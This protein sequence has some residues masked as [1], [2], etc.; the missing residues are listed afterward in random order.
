M[1]RSDPRVL[2]IGG[3]SHVGKST[4]ARSLAETWG[5]RLLST[6][7]MARH[8]GRPWR[9]PPQRVPDPVSEHYLN[10]SVG[11]L[12]T[13]VLHHY[14]SNV[15]PKVQALIRSAATG[16]SSDRLILEGSA[17][18]PE[19]VATLNFDGVAA[20]WLTARE[21]TFR[22]RIHRESLY[23]SRSGVERMM[24]D[25][26]LDRTLAYNR[27]MIQ[28]VDRHGLLRIDVEERGAEELADRCLAALDG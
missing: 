4:L 11:E 8:P 10:L 24:V 1:D 27:R 3:S 19:F 14:R 18:W 15:W 20:V 9:S 2:L 22:Q 5:W 23:H 12:F 17:L 26:F 13:D 6:D 16:P 7:T 25:R 21:G 28:V